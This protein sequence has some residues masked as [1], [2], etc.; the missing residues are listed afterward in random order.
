IGNSSMPYLNSLAAKY[1]LATQYY[2][3]THPSIGNYFMLTTGQIITNDDGFSGTVAADNIVRRFLAA[4]KT[5][6]SYA[7]G[8][9]SVGYTGG[10]SG[11]YLRRHNP[12]SYFSDVVNSSSEKLN[13]VPFTQ[14][15]KDLAN[16]QL[17]NYSFIVPDACNDA[18]DCSLTTADNWLKTN[19]APLLASP[20][21]QQ[22]GLLIITFDES[23][24]SD[25][26]HGG[27]HVAWVVVSP[28]AKSGYKSTTLYQHQSTLRLT[29]QALGLTSFPGSASTAPQMSEFFGGS[30]TPTPTPTTTTTLVPV[31][32]LTVTP[33]SGTAPLTVTADSSKS[34]ETGGSIVSRTI[35]FGDGTVVTTPTAT[36]TYPRIKGPDNKTYT[37]ALTVKDAI[38]NAATATSK[39]TVTKH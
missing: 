3:N 32:R 37:V 16:N 13:L 18:H 7:E 34:F 12:F 20:Q 22:D 30:T 24:S 25:T 8:L 36:H 19:I 23:T 14:F 26:A 10:N 5:W 6:K 15:P 31:A 33:T 38:G 1:G 11:R 28:K 17:P 35:N 21:F 2:A 39:V 4:G 29:M 27:G 9:P